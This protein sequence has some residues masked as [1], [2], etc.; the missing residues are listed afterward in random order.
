[1]LNNMEK[2]WII[3]FT[4]GAVSMMVGMI[5]YP[6]IQQFKS[7]C[8]RI[9]RNRNVVTVNINSIEKRLTELEGQMD[10]VAKN[11]YRRETNRKNNIRREVRDYLKELQK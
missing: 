11:S 8:W 7:W 9:T 2:M 4:L 1:M 6:Y 5:F 3:Y 10:N